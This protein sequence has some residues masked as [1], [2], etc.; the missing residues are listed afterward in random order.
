MTERIEKTGKLEKL[1]KLVKLEKLKKLGKIEKQEKVENAEKMDKSIKI[2]KTIKKEKIGKVASKIIN[3]V[4]FTII[5]GVIL[6]AKTMFFYHVTIETSGSILITTFIGT[7]SFIAVGVCA[8]CVLPNRLRVVGTITTDVIISIMLFVN[9]A[10]YIYSRGVLSLAQITNLQYGEQI[11]AVLPSLLQIKQILYWI[12]IIVLIGL[13]C[14]KGVKIEKKKRANIK[15]ICAR[16]LSGIA[17][18][19]IFNWGCIPRIEEGNEASYD[20]NMLIKN[21][22]IYGYYIYDI[23]NVI[24][25]NNS[26]KY[27]DKASMMKDYEALKAQYDEK[28]GEIKYN[29]AGSLAGKNIIIV[30]LESLQNFMI[31]RKIDGQEIT[32]NLNKFFN[33]NIRFTDMHMQSY[34]TT[35]DSEHSTITSVYPV[36]NG[37][38][39]S[40][41]Y[42]N[43]YDDIYKILHQNDYF[44]SYIHGN[45]AAFWNRGCVYGLLDVD[46]LALKDELDD[47][48]Y[49]NGFLSDESVYLQGAERLSEYNQPFFSYIV[50]ASSHIP[51]ELEGLQDRSKVSLDVGKYKGTYFGN[52]LEAANYAD[53]AFGVFIDKLK[54][55]GLYDDTSILVF[56][57]HNGLFMYDEYML[58]FIEQI[59]DNFTDAEKQI[60]FSNVLCGLRVPGVSNVVIDKP[61]SKLDIKPTFCYLCGIEDG[62]S[63]GTNM[64]ASKDFV[65]TNNE[66]IIT[67]KYFY[68]EGWYDR[69]TGE[70]LDLETMDQDIAAELDTYYENMRTELD[71]SNS[72]VSNNLLK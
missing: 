42:T 12:D 72:I 47:Y 2:D 32:P 60:N 11:L 54:E 67:D 36:E 1:K 33:E 68:S 71:I 50:A 19:V 18:V 56:G 21:S 43:K 26:S 65:C 16:I 10:Y 70:R 15:V 63:L 20:K 53:Y 46:D 31:N 49:I 17:C 58:E 37:M 52:Y 35:A 30:Q 48:E 66:R 57:D 28:Y 51:Y 27:K 4:W 29:L 5:I 62:F 69:A 38:A 39:F 25:N 9:N 59:D 34:T 13:F 64:F 22:T 14:I 61:I 7:L 6:L 8:L 45:D 40:K 44:T 3:S 41:Y 23:K 55:N 24:T